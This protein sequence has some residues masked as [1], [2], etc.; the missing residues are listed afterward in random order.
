MCQ[1]SR[2]STDS[3]RASA[4]VSF[5]LV[6]PYTT[7]TVFFPFSVRSRV[8]SKPWARPGQR[9][10]SVRMGVVRSV[11]RSNR[12]CPLSVVVA[13]REGGG[14]GSSG[15]KSGGDGPRRGLEAEAGGHVGGQ[16][17]LVVL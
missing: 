17:L 5:R 3:R 11:R 7:S 4:S 2:T 13:T 9:R 15:G 14:G 10:C 16:R 1:C 6:T 8:T 12:P